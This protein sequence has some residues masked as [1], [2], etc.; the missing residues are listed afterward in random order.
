MKKLFIALIMIFISGCSLFGDESKLA[1]LE[2]HVDKELLQNFSFELNVVERNKSKRFTNRDFDAK[3]DLGLPYT[4]YVETSTFGVL[5]VIFKISDSGTQQM[6][7]KGTVQYKLRE[8]Y[9]HAASFIS[10]T[11]GINPIK[12][13]MGC[14][15]YYSFD[16]DQSNMGEESPLKGRSLYVIT[17]GNSISE[18]VIY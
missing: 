17:S 5:N 12:N 9:R 11:I 8:D 7:S 6:L 18:P 15:D 13:C 16:I 2:V 4:I 14:M 3:N 1:E 10:D